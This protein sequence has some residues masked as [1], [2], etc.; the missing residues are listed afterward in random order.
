MNTQSNTTFGIEI[1]MTVPPRRMVVEP[2][3]Q[4][5][6]DLLEHIERCLTCDIRI[7]DPTR[8]GGSR[9]ELRWFSA[10]L[11]ADRLAFSFKRHS[12]HNHHVV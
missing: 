1:E 12:D 9:I 6:A 7:H 3:N 5:L 2:M 4:I 10:I 11:D 8:D